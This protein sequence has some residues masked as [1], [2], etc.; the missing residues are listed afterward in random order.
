MF[1]SISYFIIHIW[2]HVLCH[3]GINVIHFSCYRY[4]QYILK[5]CFLFL[6]TANLRLVLLN[7]IWM[8]QIIDFL[9]KN[10]DRFFINNIC[11]KIIQIIQK[12]IK[13]SIYIV[14]NKIN[15]YSFVNRF[16]T[17]RIHYEKSFLSFFY[18]RCF[19]VILCENL[20]L[21]IILN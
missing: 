10:I 18:H 8:L 6:D 13:N 14:F 4:M 2:N 20:D 7:S 19:I 9:L 1:F 17:I 11:L 3:L 16:Y 15:L 5:S 12:L 21:K